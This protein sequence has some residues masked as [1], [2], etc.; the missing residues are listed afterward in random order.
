MRQ[1]ATRELLAYWNRLRGD[2]LAPDRADVD[3][4]AI[5]GTLSDL[6][7][8][9]LDAAHQF[10]FLMAGTR[11]N[12]FFCTEQ[13]G[14]SFL[15]L[16]QPQDA[17]NVAVALMTAIDAACPILAAVNASPEGY[18]DA[19][20]EILLLPLRHGGY[21]ASRLLGLATPAAQ[22][23]VG[24]S[25]TCHAL[26]IARLAYDRSTAELGEYE[27]GFGISFRGENANKRTARG[28][29]RTSARFR[30]RQVD[31]AT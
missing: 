3:L 31:A 1:Q 29:S 28:H 2:E 12:A 23:P 26:Q 7:M 24:W 13:L 4:A 25:F 15:G 18:R 10:P 22:P 20:I 27:Q 17:R 5:R 30:R 19:D 6:F 14:R 8:L 9:D 16:W 11:L 21:A